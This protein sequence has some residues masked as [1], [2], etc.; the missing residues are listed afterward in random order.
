MNHRNHHVTMYKID[1]STPLLQEQNS[2]SI[3]Q[4]ISDFKAD[5][6]NQ[7]DIYINERINKIKDLE[8]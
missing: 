5:T 3:E 6:K 2:Q 4:L 8:T 7:V 1:E